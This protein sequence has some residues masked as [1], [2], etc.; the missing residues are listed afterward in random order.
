M[1]ECDAEWEHARVALLRKGADAWASGGRTVR[2]NVDHARTHLVLNGFDDAQQLSF[3][4]LPACWASCGRH[5]VARP[6]H[7]EARGTRVAGSGSWAHQLVGA[8]SVSNT[9]RVDPPVSGS[10]FWQKDR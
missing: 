4:E 3:R 9:V 7:A 5:C 8:N 6:A 1:R 10:F 2:T